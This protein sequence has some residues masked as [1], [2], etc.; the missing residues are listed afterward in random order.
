MQQKQGNSIKCLL[1]VLFCLLIPS[2]GLANADIDS[3]AI[4]AAVEIAVI[5]ADA[6]K[7]VS[8][9]SNPS[10]KIIATHSYSHQRQVLS[11]T[12]RYSILNRLLLNSNT[13]RA[14]PTLSI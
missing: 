1:G 12:G 8:R 7:K 5:D 13:V 14:P 6:L 4:S 2:S 10:S 11:R 3:N 9:D